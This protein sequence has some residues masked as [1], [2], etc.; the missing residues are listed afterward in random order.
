[1]RE[2]RPSS[3]LVVAALL[4]FQP[5]MRSSS[6]DLDVV[7]LADLACFNIACSTFSVLGARAGFPVLVRVVVLGLPPF[8]MPP[9]RLAAP[10]PAP[11]L[12]SPSK[13][14][15]WPLFRAATPPREARGPVG[16]SFCATILLEVARSGLAEGWVSIE[17]S[18]RVWFGLSG[19]GGVVVK[20]AAR[21]WLDTVEGTVWQA[22]RARREAEL[23]EI[24]RFGQSRQTNDKSSSLFVL[25]RFE[26]L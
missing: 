12:T 26:K 16:L 25:I 10:A 9:P 24:D 8:V 2:L 14:V 18:T 20:R 19:C 7:V 13:S 21:G 4:D 1:M 11:I 22:V 5:E 23:D 6:G 15:P 17:K 3:L